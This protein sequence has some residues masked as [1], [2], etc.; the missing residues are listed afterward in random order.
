M[1]VPKLTSTAMTIILSTHAGEVGP[2]W[3]YSQAGLSRNAEE[4]H[5]AI[6]ESAAWWT[7]LSSGVHWWRCRAPHDWRFFANPHVARCSLTVQIQ[8]DDLFPWAEPVKPESKVRPYCL[9]FGDGMSQWVAGWEG[10]LRTPSDDEHCPL[11]RA[12]R[13]AVPAAIQRKIEV[14]PFCSHPIGVSE[15]WRDHLQFGV[16][17]VIQSLCTNNLKVLYIFLFSFQ[18]KWFTISW[19]VFLVTD[20]QVW[21]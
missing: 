10:L 15:R 17:A 16:P 14:N 11:C 18:W 6:L 3:R 12:C 7:L 20:S 21:I 19:I 5:L 8:Q 1:K 13:R 9:P 2:S 4:Q